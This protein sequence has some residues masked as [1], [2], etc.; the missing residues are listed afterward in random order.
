MTAAVRTGGSRPRCHDAPYVN[1]RS[2]GAARI[3]AFLSAIL[4]AGSLQAISEARAADHGAHAGI[5]CADCHL[6]GVMTTPANAAEMPASQERLCG[7]CHRGAVE[8]AHP[9]GFTPARPV[10]AGFPLDER[11]RMTCTTCHTGHLGASGSLR[12][13]QTGEAFCLSCHGRGMFDAMPDQGLSLFRSAHLDARAAPFSHSLDRYSLA[14][15]LCH[16]EEVSFP[17]D[18]QISSLD[19]VNASR[20]A[21]HPVGMDYARASRG[22]GYRS[23]ATLDP[24]ILLVD[25]KVSCLSCHRAYTRQHGAL[26]AAGDDRTFCMSC[27]DM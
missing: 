24:D 10:P 17:G 12:T 9:T 16:E 1:P 5:P 8:A 25:G 19:P 4:I 22:K 2:P 6:A 14:C 26:V 13:A 15:A 11:G 20:S 7:R 18:H 21:N 3:L 27:H 23:P